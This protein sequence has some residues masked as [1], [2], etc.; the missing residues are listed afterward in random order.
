MIL[1]RPA[2]FV[3][4]ALICGIVLGNHIELPSTW[5]LFC[6]GVFSASA[7]LF[8]FVRLKRILSLVLILCFVTAGFFLHELRTKDFA[9]NHISHFLDL[10]RRVSLSGNICRDPDIRQNKTF[11][12]LDVGS[13]LLDGKFIE[14]SGKVLIKIKSS[15][16]RFNYGDCVRVSGFLRAPE[17]SR[18]PGA[19]DYR[20]YLAQAKIF[21]LMSLRSHHDVE[22]LFR[23]K[24]NPFLSNVV[25]PVKHF[26][27]RVF[28]STLKGAHGA[29]LSGFVL[30]ERRDIPEETYRMFTDTG[31]LHL[32]AISGSNVGLVV[33]FFFGFL[34]LARVP[35]KLSILLTLPAIVIF[36]YVT[37]NQPSVVRA[38]IMASVFLLAFFWEREKDLVN[39]LAF[40]ALLIL[41]F[42]PLSLF[43][44]GF[45]LSFG[46]TLGLVLFV[47]H[48]H[49]ILYKAA[50]KFKGLLRNW[51]ILPILVSLVAQISSYPILAYHFN[52]I[53]LYAF[54]ANLLVVPLVSLAVITGSMTVITALV[55]MKLAQIL[56]AFNW[57]VLSLTLRVVE[58]F[59][60]L[61]HATVDLPS[62]SLQC[63]V[64][65]YLFFVLFLISWGRKVKRMGF[66]T[67]VILGILIAGREALIKKDA[68]EIT[69]LDVGQG[70]SILI[71]LPPERKI[72]IDTGPKYK[73]S[74]A[75][76]RVV[77]PHLIKKNIKEIDQ[78]ILTSKTDVFNGGLEAVL[79][80]I[81][82]KEAIILDPSERLTQL[83]AD[84]TIPCLLPE[85]RFELDDQVKIF[86]HLPDKKEEGCLFT[87]EYGGFRALFISSEAGRWI[88][89]ILRG[90]DFHVM[91]ATLETMGDEGFTQMADLAHARSIV[92]TN[93]KNPWQELDRKKLGLE[94]PVFWTRDCG[95]ISLKVRKTDFELNWMLGQKRSQKFNLR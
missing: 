66:F 6:L 89:N 48:P 93:Y 68:L 41:I 23:E 5:L 51:V 2:L 35:R 87:L 49:S 18:N 75:G 79:G 37:N 4:L 77:V 81:R 19:F 64:S 45:Q 62:P 83:L 8:Y 92:L 15:T 30:G 71:E 52:Q 40:S 86:A 7:L 3:A 53:S 94:T 78:L 10:N 13:I 72:L 60:Q 29:L 38:S 28:R 1:R 46:V 56:S 47:V 82:V 58:F 16:N 76:E 59:S 9:P 44:V 32:L 80:E 26:I 65:Y 67:L 73:S 31:T 39:V 91:S 84:Y 63:L 88:S 20:K 54:L 85:G 12:S 70:Q 69:F 34:R 22:I 61:P 95:A 14:T 57:V 21:G 74:D 55:S 42:S 90:K 25:Y 27:L 36:S 24:E 11:L 17:S 33:L 43:D 50:F